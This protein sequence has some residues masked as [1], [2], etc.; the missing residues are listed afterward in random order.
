MAC[1]LSNYALQIYYMILFGNLLAF[2]VLCPARTG[3]TV[4]DAGDSTMPYFPELLARVRGLGVTALDP[5][6]STTTC[7]HE[8]HASSWIVPR[9]ERER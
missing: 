8:L 7:F 1:K 4:A 9:G 5:G 6:D 2:T 3:V